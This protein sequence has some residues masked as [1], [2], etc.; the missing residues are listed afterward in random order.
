MTVERYYKKHFSHFLKKQSRA[1][2]ASIEDHI[3]LISNNPLLGE[4]K[5]GDLAD[6]RVYKFKFNRQEYLLA[7]KHILLNDYIDFYQI[8]VHENFYDELKNYIKTF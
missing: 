6:I 5:T 1:F 2:Q 7:Y 3:E 8:G 4:L